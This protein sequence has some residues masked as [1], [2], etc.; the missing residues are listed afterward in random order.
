MRGDRPTRYRAN[1]ER[2]GNFDVDGVRLL[3]SHLLD[4]LSIAKNQST[5]GLGGGYLAD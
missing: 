2:L 3:G 4:G 5:R 1:V